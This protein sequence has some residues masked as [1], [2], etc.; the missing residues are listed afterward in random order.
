MESSAVVGRHPARTVWPGL[1]G[2]AAFLAIAAAGLWWAK[3]SP[4]GH[5]LIHLF[6]TPHWSGTSSLEKAGAAGSAPSLSGAW[7]FTTGYARAVWPGFI[8][9]LLI[10][11]AVDA[12]VPRSW[13]LATL[14]RTGEGRSALVGGLC[15]LPSLMCTCC[16]APIAATLRRDGAPTSAA[17]AYWMGN[18]VLN[19]AVLAFLAIVA[20]WQWVVTRIVV[21]GVLVFGATVLVA[22]L[23]PTGSAPPAV[24]PPSAGFALPGAPAR[25]AQTLV[26]LSLTLVPLYFVVVFA[27]GL[28]RGWLFP[29]DAATAHW[30]VPSIFAAA[31]LGTLI[32][33]P[34][35]GEIPILQALATA[36][37]GAGT[38]G[39]LL[40]TL[41]A[42]SLAS[43]AMVARAFS[44]RVTVAMAGA[45]AGC[46]LLAGGLLVL[47]SG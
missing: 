30:V 10:A 36:G 4:Y 39:A 22:R 16:T 26:R 2:L 45:V 19:P 11:S 43:M 46:G 3:W 40:I 23:A 32:V 1:A 44:V 6:A 38:I 42:I 28:F 24:A 12:L 37:V 27:L 35:A 21:G 9:A 31:A 41:P 7:S 47:L 13:V 14:R 8:A 34:T 15:A 18:P 25:F 33:I 20:P 29:L 17:L 5:K